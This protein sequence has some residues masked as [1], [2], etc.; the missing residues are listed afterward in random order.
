MIAW[1]WLGLGL[2]AA[3]VKNIMPTSKDLPLTKVVQALMDQK[4][5][6]EADA[7]LYFDPKR[8][9]VGVCDCM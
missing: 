5:H 7:F 9:M 3:G 6:P 1:R 4:S 8:G 2:L